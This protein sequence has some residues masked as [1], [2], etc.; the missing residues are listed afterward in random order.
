MSTRTPAA[1]AAAAALS[2]AAFLGIAGVTAAQSVNV[3]FDMAF[4]AGVGPPGISF[5]AAAGYTSAF[6]SSNFWNSVQTTG[7]DMPLRDTSAN[8]SPVRISVFGNFGFSPSLVTG[9]FDLLISDGIT[10]SPGI[11][12]SGLLPGR[13][14]VY[15]YVASDSGC[16]FRTVPESAPPTTQTATY[17]PAPFNGFSAGPDAGGSVSTHTQHEVTVAADGLL[18]IRPT[19]L[20]GCRVA[21]VQLVHRG[22]VPAAVGCSISG[23]SVDSCVSGS[24]VI[25]GNIAGPSDVSFSLAYASSIAGPFT[26]FAAGSGPAANTQLALLDTAPLP[27]GEYFIR[28]SAQ[29]PAGA[30]ASSLTA[31]RVR[32]VDTTAPLAAINFP[33]PNARVCNAVTIAGNVSDATLRSWTLDYAGPLTT[34]W[35]NIASG[36]ANVPNGPIA[37]W[38][39]AGL[40]RG[41]YT[42]RLRATD[43]G[44]LACNDPIGLTREVVRPLIVGLASDLS[45]D[46]TVNTT[47]LS[48]FLGQFGASCQ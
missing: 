43:S 30:S 5:A 22:S 1:F 16:Q 17:Q 24:V 41:V 7:F 47:D 32:P 44:S 20:S 40:P 48:L 13:Y 6:Q 34:G 45:F 19:F 11:D 38:N 37:T 29:T 21:G 10:P 4:G 46:G 18:S 2:F 25:S 31:I 23:P 8:L 26:A 12:F 27:P 28:L 39:T 42:L 36:T 33:L 15:T 9:E 3:D 14:S 35:V